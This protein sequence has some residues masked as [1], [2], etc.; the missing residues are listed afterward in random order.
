MTVIIESPVADAVEGIAV[1]VVCAALA[2]PTVKVT[3][4]VSVIAGPSNVPLTVITSA[5]VF[6]MV[7]VYVPFP[8]SV[9][10]LNVALPFSESV[11]VEPPVVKLF[12][13]A[14]LACMVIVDVMTPSAVTEGGAD[15]IVVWDATADPGV[16]VTAS[17]SVMA[18]PFNVPSTV[19]TS[20]TV[21]VMVAVYVPFPLSVTELIVALPFSESVT[22]EPPVVK[23]FPWASLVCTVIVEVATPSAVTEV[24]DDEIVV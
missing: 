18:R 8:L 12:P 2:A 5:A 23:L 9:T 20:A 16:K 1:I 11:I 13:W 17:V 15:D 6:V 24:G 10:E 4:A 7:A 14:S 21:F 19:I 3:N 22:V